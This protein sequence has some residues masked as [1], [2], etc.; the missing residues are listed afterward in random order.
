MSDSMGSECNVRI[1]AGNQAM[2][3]VGS[4]VEDGGEFRRCLRYG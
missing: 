4:V 1:D 3:V 2:F